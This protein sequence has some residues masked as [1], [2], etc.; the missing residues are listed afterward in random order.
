MVEKKPPAA[1]PGAARIDS[2]R[3]NAPTEAWLIERVVEDAAQG[4]GGTVF[5][6]NLDH[7]AKLRHDPAF[8]AA[9]ER[10]TYITADGMPVV[11]LARAT[12][13]AIERVTGA[14]LVVP[15]CRAAAAAGIPIY[16]FGTRRDI[17]DRAVERLRHDIPALSVAGIEAPPMGFD[18]Q[19]EAA[20][21]AAERIGASGAGIC[22]VALGAPKQEL[23]ANAALTW[24][25]GVVYLGVGAALDFLAGERVRAPRALQRVGLEWLWRTLQEPRRLLPR[26][27]ASAVWLV[28]YLVRATLGLTDDHAA[29]VDHPVEPRAS[30]ERRVPPTLSTPGR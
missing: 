8:R 9:Y 16:F 2:W 14:D 30:T 3:I 11:V 24:S 6:I 10:A 27:V 28:G 7:F 18:P 21:E 13:A 25:N 19:G 29:P 17:L 12:G 4:R 5:T 26:Y 22:F 15:L 23:F 20:R 1:S